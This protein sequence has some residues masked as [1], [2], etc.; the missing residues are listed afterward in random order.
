[1]WYSFLGTILTVFFGICIS[2]VTE[3]I[4]QTK[5]LNLAVSGS[6]SLAQPTAQQRK[7]AGEFET[8]FIVEKYRKSTV[9]ALPMQHMNGFD[10]K[11]M[12]MDES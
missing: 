9:D 7:A 5:I 2:L 1:M 8:V 11:A 12:R 3:K 10:N 4:S 6:N